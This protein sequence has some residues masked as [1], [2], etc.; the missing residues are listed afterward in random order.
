MTGA[1][2]KATVQPPKQGYIPNPQ[3][4]S[5]PFSADIDWVPSPG[6]LKNRN[7]DPVQNTR[8]KPM[9]PP[10][11]DTFESPTG[12]PTGSLSPH[13]VETAKVRPAVPR[14][15]LSLSSQ[16]KIGT[17]SPDGQHTSWQDSPGSGV[18][19]HTGSTDL[20]SDSA[21]EQ[22]EWKPLLQ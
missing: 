22:I 18:T 20:L 10:R 6:S 8:E 1:S 19:A 5:N 4:K 15:P 3:R 9:L 7:T 14:K 11:R 13:A 17:V 16:A 2:V 21:S 12:N